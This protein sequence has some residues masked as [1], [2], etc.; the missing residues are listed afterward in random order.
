[1]NESNEASVC[2]YTLSV[3]L[4]S[5]GVSRVVGAIIP[6]SVGSRGFEGVLVPKNAKSVHCGQLLLSYNCAEN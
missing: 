6:I 1:M 2:C 3:S 4:D 5:S